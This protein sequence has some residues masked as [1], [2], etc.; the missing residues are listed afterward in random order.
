VAEMGKKWGN[1]KA[2]IV[3]VRIIGESFE[4]RFN[5]KNFRV[6]PD[7]GGFI[8]IGPGADWCDLHC[9]LDGM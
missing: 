6:F 4:G 9:L 2:G 8:A 5:L 7:R 1:A 3:P